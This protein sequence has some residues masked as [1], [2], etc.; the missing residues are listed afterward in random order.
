MIEKL[1]VEKEQHLSEIRRLQQELATRDVDAAASRQAALLKQHA[2]IH[3]VKAQHR[4]DMEKARRDHEKKMKE[5]SA[6]VQSEIDI[7]LAKIRQELEHTKQLL[8]MERMER[9][10]DQDLH[11]AELE[12]A[13]DLLE[14]EPTGRACDQED[15]REMEQEALHEMEL[16]HEK[17]LRE[18]EQMERMRED[19][20][21][22]AERE[23][24]GVEAGDGPENEEEVTYEDD[25]ESYSSDCSAGSSC[26]DETAS[27]RNGRIV[28]RNLQ[29]LT[30]MSWQ[31]AGPFGDLGALRSK[32]SE[33]WLASQRRPRKGPVRAF[34][35]VYD[36]VKE[37]PVT[38]R[39][40]RLPQPSGW[41]DY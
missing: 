41:Q 13:K 26:F 19:D 14:M 12:H 34:R 15:L 5:K 9:L 38:E 4:K 7:A 35:P 24:L 39:R 40:S 20:L 11:E 36:C 32:L 6:S 3:A 16:E 10:H 23:R 22:E 37:S 28:A 21:R 30:K 29:K 18:L 2:E 8:E 27:Q 33:Q 31:L 17:Q 1:S 25:W